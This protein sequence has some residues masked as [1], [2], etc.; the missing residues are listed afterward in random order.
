MAVLISVIVHFILLILLG[1]WTVYRYVQ[2]GDPGMEVAME[3]GEEATVEEQMEEVEVTEVQPNVEVDLDRLV[4]DPI[5]DVQLPEITADT[6]AVPTPPVPSVPTTVADQVAF[7][8]VAPRGSWGN[9]FGSSDESDF[10]LSGK[11]YDFKQKPDGTSSGIGR[12][13]VREV[14]EFVESGFDRRTIDNKFF[15]APEMRSV[16]FIAHLYMNADLAP[17]AYDLEGIVEGERWIIH[18]NGVISPQET[19]RYRFTAYADDQALVAIDGTVVVDGSRQK[20]SDPRYHGSRVHGDMPGTND[21]GHSRTSDWIQMNA[22]RNY[23]IDIIVGEN[24]GGRY[25]AWILV[26]KEGFEYEQV[27]GYP[28]LH[29]FSTIEMDGP[30]DFEQAAEELG[31]RSVRTPPL[32]DEVLAFPRN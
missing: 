13:F 32:Q 29:L 27:G 30:P 17:K 5:H 21:S 3:Q 4:V 6:Q 15:S 23:D 2:E 8:Q 19:G 31:L 26:E 28:R 25:M 20:I 22:N 12:N 7:R 16:S 10:L 14:R 11:F 1:L 18:Y 24:P 9:V